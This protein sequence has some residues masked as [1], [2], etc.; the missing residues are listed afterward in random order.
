[1]WGGGAGADFLLRS[2][3]T[4]KNFYGDF[5]AARGKGA[6]WREGG[7]RGGGEGAGRG[8]W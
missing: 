6:R 3:Q 1:M 7:G 5:T 2:E 8:G 4:N